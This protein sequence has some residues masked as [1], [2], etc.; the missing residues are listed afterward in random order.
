MST[1]VLAIAL[2]SDFAVPSICT[3]DVGHLALLTKVPTLVA[4]RALVPGSLASSAAIFY[5]AGGQ[6]TDDCRLGSGASVAQ[7]RCEGGGTGTGT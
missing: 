7:G 2:C 3:K 6:M 5:R 4:V 1:R